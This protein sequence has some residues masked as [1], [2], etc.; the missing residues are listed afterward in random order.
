MGKNSIASAI[1]VFLFET[2]GNGIAAAII[3]LRSCSGGV[4]LDRA[5]GARNGANY[6]FKQSVNYRLRL[7]DQVIGN[8]KKIGAPFERH[9]RCDTA[10][11]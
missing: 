3:G 1:A 5:S 11:A 9:S 8:N 2:S 4:P 10:P 7:R 6:R